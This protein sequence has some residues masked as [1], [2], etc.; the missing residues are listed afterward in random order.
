MMTLAMTLLDRAREE[1]TPLIDGDQVTFVWYGDGAEPAPY[2]V[3]DFNDWDGERRPIHLKEVEPGVWAHTLTL[4]MDAYIEYAYMLSREERLSDPFNPYLIWN[5]VDAVNHAFM[6][7]DCQMTDLIAR[8][9]GVKRGTL[10]KHALDSGIMTAWSPRD[11]YLYQPPVDVPVPL[12]VVWDG[13][14]Y[15]RRAYLTNIV[16]NLIAQGRIPPLALALLANGREARMIE[17]Y[18]NDMTIGWVLNQVIPFAQ[19]KLNLID[20]RDQPGAYG[21]LGASMG[22]LMALYAGVRA[23]MVFGKVISQSG[24]FDI[25][26]GHEMIIDKLIRLGEGRG[27][28]IWQDVGTMEFLTEGN[29]KMHRLLTE[30]GYDV[31]YHEYNGGHNYT[32]WGNSVWRGLETVFGGEG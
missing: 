28:K 22:G 26:Q 27:I 1:G 18:H 11:I 7:P 19:D 30:Q 16:D 24:A 4:P 12:V 6:M 10:T 5:G 31:T 17:Y 15:S 20:Y 29:R 2:L 13:P 3:G 8:K 25:A 23:P 14:D 9:K 21:V 32:M